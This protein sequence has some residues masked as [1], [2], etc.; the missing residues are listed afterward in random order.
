MWNPIAC[1][2]NTGGKNNRASIEI[3][4]LRQNPYCI[5]TMEIINE[6]HSDRRPDVGNVI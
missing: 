2:S 3:E 5:R 6:S 4:I 1:Q